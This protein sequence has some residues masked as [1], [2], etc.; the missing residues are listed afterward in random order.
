MSGKPFYYDAA[1]GWLEVPRADLAEL[2]ILG[3]ISGFSY[4]RGELVYLEEDR[5]AGVWVLACERAGRTVEP[6]SE[7]DDGDQSAIRGMDPF[8][9]R[10]GED[11][12]RGP[13][14]CDAPAPNRKG[15]VCLRCCGELGDDQDD[16][17]TAAEELAH[18]AGRVSR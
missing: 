10:D 1:H 7:R 17:R 11:A 4:E 2:G 18:R 8:R 13:C 15:R 9:L 3:R 16:G 5:D 12:T 6:F 14:W